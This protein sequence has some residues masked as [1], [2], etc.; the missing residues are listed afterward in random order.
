MTLI[1]TRIG[2]LAAASALALL[3]HTTDDVPPPQPQWGVPIERAPSPLVWP[4]RTSRQ[5]RLELAKLVG[6]TQL[7]GQSG[8]SC[9]P[10]FQYAQQVTFYPLETS[11]PVTSVETLVALAEWRDDG[12]HPLE[13]AFLA[14]RLVRYFLPEW[15]RPDAWIDASLSREQTRLAAPC[16]R[17]ADVGGIYVIVEYEGWLPGRIKYAKITITRDAAYISGSMKDWLFY[18]DR[19]MGFGKVGI[20]RF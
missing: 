11:G 7:R 18:C 8:N 20:D 9:T 5:M 1:L 14:K 10:D 2:S 15:K 17:I 13:M 3:P 12:E 4:E 19:E 16:T 6:C